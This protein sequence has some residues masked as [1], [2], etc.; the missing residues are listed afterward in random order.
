MRNYASIVIKPIIQENRNSFV[1]LR[2]FEN[3]KERCQS[4]KTF[5]HY[6]K[7]LDYFLNFCHKDYDSLLLL[8]QNELEQVLQ[9]FTIF[10]KRRVER[11][12]ISPNSVPVFLNGV[13]KFLKVNRKKFDKDLITE[14]YPR[15]N[16]LGGELAITTEQCKIMLDS[17][18]KKRDKALIH[19]YCATGARPEAICELQ[20][21]Y[22]Q[23]YQDGFF[24]VVLYAGDVSEMFTF[25]HPEASK[26]LTEYLEWRKTTVEVLTD[27]SPVFRSNSYRARITE[28][29]PMTMNVMESVMV[30]LWKYSG[31]KRVKT[32]K[33]YDLASTTSFRKRFDTILEFN[34]EV[35]MGATQYLMNHDGYMS[36]KHYRRPTVEQ[37]FQAYE[38]ASSQL[39]VSDE[40]R[41]KL[42]LE[43][44]SSKAN[45]VEFLKRKIANVETLLLELQSRNN[46]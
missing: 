7:N 5:H 4:E 12:E 15:R 18:G 33:R 10:L 1:K 19:F 21:K 31:I 2:C 43:K 34:H 32:G 20:M 40:L 22:V 42:K 44:E 26:A 11:G 24:K 35:S 16:K 14:L 8:P 39:M 28:P 46:T 38:K 3:F 29:K 45:E 13:F 37:V 23:H 27:E 9:D 41:L 30:R 6:K 36:G 25:L 17:T